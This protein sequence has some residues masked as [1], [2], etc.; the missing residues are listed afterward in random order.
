MALHGKF[1]LNDAD[2]SP[3]TFP[4]VG[5]FLA[6][7][8]DGACRNHVTCGAIPTQGPVPAGLYW[9]VDRPEGSTF[10]Q[11]RAIMG[12]TFNRT[13]K[14]AVFSHSKWFALFP[15]NWGN[16]K[17]SL[18]IEGVSRGGFRLHPGQ[19]SEGCI[20]LAHNTDFGLLRNALLRTTKT[21][22]TCMKNMMAYG[23]IKV[24]TNG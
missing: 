12:D 15:D 3:L 6:F 17:D 20:T 7:S 5:T 22:V 19:L 16:V 23:T 10:N 14:G 9:I 11:V 24:I 13:F 18:W 4:G 2:Y 21:P 1:E 8:G